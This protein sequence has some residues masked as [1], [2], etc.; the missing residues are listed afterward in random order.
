M[1][2]HLYQVLA[3]S[4]F[5]AA[6]ACIDV[7][8]KIGWPYSEPG[9]WRTLNSR[10]GLGLVVAL[11]VAFLISLCPLL[12]TQWTLA[13]AC[14][15][16]FWV[17]YAV[18]ANGT[19]MAVRKLDKGHGALGGETWSAMAGSVFG[20]SR[21]GLFVLAGVAALIAAAPAWALSA[22]GPLDFTKWLATTLFGT[23][24][25]AGQVMRA[26]LV[27]GLAVALVAANLVLASTVI[28]KL[29]NWRE[30]KASGSGKNDKDKKG[31]KA[32]VSATVRVSEVMGILERMVIT[33][34]A[35]MGEFTAAGFVAAIKAFGVSR[36]EKGGPSG[37]AAVVGTLASVLIA[38][39]T[40]LPARWLLSLGG[41]F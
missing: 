1:T 37:E 3:I 39:A 28:D 38:L 35:L 18:V 20:L 29:L 6:T 4:W 14:V 26:G 15:V 27:A 31:K 32:E 40:A 16:G 36:Y 34:L 7:L 22:W 30:D 5:V 12:F 13:S 17:V 8:L 19:G 11:V 41:V 24:L 23:D 21:A 2:S 9:R 10:E 33:V 25:S